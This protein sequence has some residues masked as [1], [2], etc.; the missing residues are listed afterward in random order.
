MRLLMRPSGMSIERGPRPVATRS[1][2]AS[3]LPQASGG[4]ILR[5]EDKNGASMRIVLI[6][7]ATLLGL[8]VPA[9]ADW[10][11]EY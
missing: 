9:W 6:A 1:S 10:R 7:L 2:L 5:A 8:A 3:G 4:P 11:S